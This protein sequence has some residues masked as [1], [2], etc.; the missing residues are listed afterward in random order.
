MYRPQLGSTDMPISD[1]TNWVALA[2]TR[3]QTVTLRSDGTLW[4]WEFP[5]LSFN[6]RYPG[7][8][9][10]LIHVKPL[11]LGRHSDWIGVAS[12]FEGIVALAADGSVWR[13][14]FRSSDR[15]RVSLLRASRRS[16]Y[17]GNIF[18]EERR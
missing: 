16:Q 13:W 6:A 1:E 18:T 4:K 3:E 12:F 2:G 17:V 14:Q 9:A 8:I 15:E 7:D 5:A 10:S 11:Q